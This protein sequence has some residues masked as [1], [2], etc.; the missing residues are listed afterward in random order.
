MATRGSDGWGGG[1]GG[2]VSVTSTWKE[3]DYWAVI[4]SFKNT[5]TVCYPEIEPDGENVKVDPER[6]TKLGPLKVMDTASP[7]ASDIAGRA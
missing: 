6:V 3:N 1:D 5:V 2:R 7:S 4:P